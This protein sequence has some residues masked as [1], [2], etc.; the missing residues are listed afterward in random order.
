MEDTLI[1]KFDS[2]LRKKIDNTYQSATMLI[3]GSSQS[4]IRPFV[5]IVASTELLSFTLIQK[6]PF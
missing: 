6:F 5:I 3:S 4:E 1:T 2:N